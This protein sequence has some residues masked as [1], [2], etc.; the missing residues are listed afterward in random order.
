M[1]RK[2]RLKNPF[3]DQEQK[4]KKSLFYTLELFGSFN[5]R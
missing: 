2:R 4:N 3:G 5:K 1:K